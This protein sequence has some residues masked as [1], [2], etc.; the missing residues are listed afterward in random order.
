MR[1]PEPLLPA[2]LVRRYKRFLADVIL[3]GVTAAGGGA[4]TV[5]CA[6]PGAMLG[7]DMPGSE[8]WLSRSANPAR[9]LPLSWEL[10]RV[11]GHLVGINTGHPNRLVAEAIAVG[12]I[13]ELTGYAGQ[14]REVAYGRNSRIDILLE[15][16][17]R[18]PCYVE[19][20]NV[21]LRRATAAEF[22]DSVTARGAKHLDEMGTMV[23][24]GARAV[25]V[26]L[27]QRGDC[28]RFRIAGDIDPAYARALARA[29]DR[30]VETV[31]HACA[32][33]TEGIEVAGP[34]PLDL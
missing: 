4:T 15:A 19:V 1:F 12:Q 2:R 16:P 9:K 17:D 33:T 25:M 21:H 14:R 23:E 28:D 29:R 11:D 32:I 3:D 26:Y 30:G 20:K 34:L 31:C 8:I 13:P 18:P 10:I 6:N 24:A 5:H 22:P 7:L 27:V